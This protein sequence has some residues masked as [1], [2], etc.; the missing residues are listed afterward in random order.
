MRILI[1]GTV[2]APTP[3]QRVLAEQW[4]EVHRRLNPT[5]DLLLVDSAHSIKERLTGTFVYSFPDNIG[6]LARGGQD[7]WGRAFCWGLEY[8]I[9]QGYDYV[10]HIEGDSLFRLPVEPICKQLQRDGIRA[11]SVRV[12]GTR[13]AE[14]KWTETGLMFFE[15]NYLREK[16]LVNKYNWHNGASKKYPRTPEF[17]LANII[18]SALQVM[19]WRAIRDDKKM[20][21]V[22][23]VVG[24]DW[25]THS[26]LAIYDAFIKAVAVAK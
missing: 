10:V 12:N 25:I 11:A 9:S 1:F 6:H 22:G 14:V 5:C 8:A 13:H 3:E 7:G 26:T 16:D 24:F 21:T 15:V 23:N 2:Y 18:G 19:P 4:S 20:L 17:H